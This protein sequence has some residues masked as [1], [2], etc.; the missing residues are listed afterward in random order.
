MF[1]SKP[2][3]FPV[4]LFLVLF[5]IPV[6]FYNNQENFI[7]FKMPYTVNIFF[8]QQHIKTA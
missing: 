7:F 4:L 2:A 5:L 8:K 1:G 6:L 3:D